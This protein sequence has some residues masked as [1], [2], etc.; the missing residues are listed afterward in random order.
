MQIS[1]LLAQYY[2]QTILTLHR[3]DRI[4]FLSAQQRH[5]TLAGPQIAV[6]KKG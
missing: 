6:V 4:S 2:C 1:A 5:H 3:K